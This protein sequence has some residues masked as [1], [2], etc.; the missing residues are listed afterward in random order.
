MIYIDKKNYIQAD[1]IIETMPNW[2]KGVRNGRELIKKKSIDTKHFIYARFT[3]NTWTKT[4][5]KSV[6]Y[7]KVFIRNKYLDNCEQYL[8]EV[9]N[10]NVKNDKGI[11]KA[12][13]VIILEDEEKF[14]DDDGNIVEIETRGTRNHDNIYFKVKH[15]AYGFGI[16][17]L[18]NSLLN[19]DGAYKCNN[20]YKYFTCIESDN[21]PGTASKK[22]I[23]KNEI[24]LTYEGILRVLFVSRSG[25]TSNFIKWATETLFSAQMGTSEQ[26]DKLVSKILGVSAEAVKEVF[27]ISSTSL[28]CVYLFS[29]NTVK[30]LRESMQIN[31]KYKDCMLVCKFG[32]TNDLPRRTGE[33]I[34]TYGTIKGTDLK[35][36]HYSYIDPMY[37]S[38]GEAD[39]KD[40]FT[41]LN[42]NLSYEKY[43]ELVVISPSLLKTVDRQ[44]K[45]LANAYA[46]HIKDMI[47]EVEDLK[48]QIQ[49]NNAN[50]KNE[51][52][53]K[54]HDL[55]KKEHENQLLRKDLEIEKLKKIKNVKRNQKEIFI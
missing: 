2:C 32:F 14:H 54:E 49:L 41:A 6:K 44:Y 50:H 40:F 29:L 46:G 34:K 31:K 53:Q 48:K 55:I 42:I 47:K 4:E 25:K 16:K 12:P 20:D 26:K 52:L 28:P 30:E 3:D 43:D 24:Y 13:Q 23:T 38:N 5:G 21:V 11:D 19:I 22:Q 45:Q 37:I 8:N 18:S 39:I 51:I 27:K 1:T 17:N 10:E 7:D 9:N 36:K 33:H 35:L 15:V